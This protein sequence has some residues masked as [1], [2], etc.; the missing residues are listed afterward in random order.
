MKNTYFDLIDQTFYFPQ[1]GFNLEDGRLFFNQISLKYL[2]EKYRTPFKVTFLP[3]IG[4][5]VKKARNLFNKSIKKNNYS[6]SYHF[7]YCTKCN[8]FNFVIETVLKHKVNIE[9]SSAFDIDIILSLNSDG[10]IPRETV[11]IHNGH[12]TDSYIEKI[13]ELH[14]AGLNR[15]IIV[16]DSKEELGRICNQLEGPIQV[17]IRMATDQEPQSAYYTSRLGI[18][19]NEILDFYRDHIKENPRVELKMLH[20]FIDSGIK[21]SLFYW[22]MFRKA[23][24]LYSSLKV[25]C[26]SLNAINLGGGLPIRNSLGFEYDYKYVVNELVSSLKQLCQSEGIPEPDIFTE[27][28]KYTVGEGGATIFKVL[29]VKRQNDN[30]L[31]YMIDNSL[32]TTIPDSWSLSTKFILLPVNKWDRPYT[33]VNIGG[34][35]CDSSDY[36]NSEEMNQQVYLP[37]ISGKEEEPLYLGFFH[38]GAYQ[39]SLGGYGGIKHCLI[40]SPKHIIIDRDPKSGHL[41]DYLFQEEQRPEDMLRILGYKIKT[42]A[43]HPIR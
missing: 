28:G 20:F 32:M 17:G 7:A 18:R 11:F 10:K 34:I 22:G 1:E 40:P 16:L 27:F 25:E 8:H 9:T 5:Q 12:K 37:E 35:S 26:E 30:E 2:I 19:P 36:Y 29:E 13:G 4:D 21:D 14:K 42:H 6:G 3:K 33:Q 24:A 41:T 43:D 38:T 15:S 31:W 39:D 23:L